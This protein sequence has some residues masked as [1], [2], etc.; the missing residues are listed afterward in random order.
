MPDSRLVR[1]TSN[2]AVAGLPMATAPAP[3]SGRRRW[4]KFSAREHSAHVNTCGPPAGPLQKAPNSPVLPP[5]KLLLRRSAPRK[6]THK[7]CVVQLLTCC[8]VSLPTTLLAAFL[9]AASH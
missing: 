1:Q 7:G 8:L 5:Q 3:S 2:S 9:L 4:P 6:K